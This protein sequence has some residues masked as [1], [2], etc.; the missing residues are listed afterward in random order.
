M[1]KLFPIKRGIN[2]ISQIVCTLMTKLAMTVTLLNV[3]AKKIRSGRR[4]VSYS[5]SE[6]SFD[7]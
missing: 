5:D 6:D 1:M 7:E 2:Q 4:L 3:L